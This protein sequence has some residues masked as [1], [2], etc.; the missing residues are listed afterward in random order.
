MVEGGYGVTCKVNAL[1]NYRQPSISMLA[2]PA[3][4]ALSEDVEKESQKVRS[5]YEQGVPALW[6]DGR[7]SSMA[8]RLNIDGALQDPFV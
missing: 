4:K 6:E 1:T 7:D 2:C 8:Q 3:P 5:M